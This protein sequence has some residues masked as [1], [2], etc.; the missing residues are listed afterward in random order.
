M[1]EY[2]FFLREI[3]TEAIPFFLKVYYY[4]PIILLDIEIK[5]FFVY[6][7]MFLSLHRVIFAL[8]VS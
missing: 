2:R 1:F 6:L 8:D 3:A 4:H 5:V 7:G